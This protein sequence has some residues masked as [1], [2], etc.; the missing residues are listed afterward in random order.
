MDRNDPARHVA[1]TSTNT[2]FAQLLGY[3]QTGGIVLFSPG[4]QGYTCPVHAHPSGDRFDGLKWSEYNACVWCPVCDRDYPSALCTGLTCDDP[5][6]LERAIEVFI[7]TV[8]DA[9]RRP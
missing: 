6:A 7:S 3:R 5:A 8:R 1:G 9:L 2:A 4:E